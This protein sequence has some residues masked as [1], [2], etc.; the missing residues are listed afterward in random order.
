LL[1]HFIFSQVRSHEA[2]PQLPVVGDMEV[3]EFV[4]DH[5]ILE[6]VIEIEEL[7]VEGQG[8]VRGTGG[9]LPGHRANGD[10]ADLNV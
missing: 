7:G 6:F 5:V 9:P 10:R 2:L 8:T 3:E 1:S 4:D